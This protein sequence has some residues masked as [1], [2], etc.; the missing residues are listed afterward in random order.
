[1]KDK[2]KNSGT[3]G[4]AIVLLIIVVLI[5]LSIV[6][7]FWVD[8]ANE[9]YDTL[10]SAYIKEK[11]DYEAEDQS[12]LKKQ[13]LEKGMFIKMHRWDRESFVKD[14]E[15]YNEIVKAYNR[16]EARREEREGGLIDAV[17]NL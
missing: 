3:V 4:G 7:Y 1:M 15:L 9:Y 16:Q 14:R 13:L 6:R 12:R 11:E 2:Y 8:V 10:I 5:V 17:I